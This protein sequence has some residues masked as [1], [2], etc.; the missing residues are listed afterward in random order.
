VAIVLL[1]QYVIMHFAIV[2]KLNSR[3]IHVGRPGQL[4]LIQDPSLDVVLAMNENDWD[5]GVR[6]N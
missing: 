5:Q 1:D 6:V 4:L 2:E 3:I